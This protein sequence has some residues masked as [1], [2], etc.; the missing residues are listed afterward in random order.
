VSSRD[1][2]KV[3]QGPQAHILRLANLIS[4]QALLINGVVSFEIIGM[5]GQVIRLRGSSFRMIPNPTNDHWLKKIGSKASWKI[6]RLMEVFQLKLKELSDAEG[7]GPTHE[8]TRI[9]KQWSKISALDCTDEA[10]LSIQCREALHDALDE[11]TEYLLKLKQV[12][13]LNVLVAHITKVIEVL[14]DPNSPL[15][16]I[17]LA[18]KEDA[19]LSHYFNEIRPAV[20]VFDSNKKPLSKEDKEMRNTIWISLI[21]RMLCWLLIHDFDKADVKMVPSDLRGSRMPIFIG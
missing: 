16:T 10:N 3:H 15:N 1:A 11:R 2:E 17:V 21:F 20:I 6:T 4:P 12:E 18:N 9:R 14:D 19:L 5:L 8:I 7:F 13:V